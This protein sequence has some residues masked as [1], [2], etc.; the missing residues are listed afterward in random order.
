MF[1]YN[2][3]TLTSNMWELYS[4]HC[5]FCHTGH[6]TVSS[7][8]SDRVWVGSVLSAK[9]SCREANFASIDLIVQ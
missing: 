3:G 9:S 7:Q 5:V 2:N 8:V 1:E 6:H 4:V